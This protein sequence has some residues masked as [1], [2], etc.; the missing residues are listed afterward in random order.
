MR[1]NNLIQS[2]LDVEL[3]YL[4]CKYLVLDVL[5][6]GQALDK[7]VH[8]SRSQL[9]AL[10]NISLVVLAAFNQFA[11]KNNDCLLRRLQLLNDALVGHGKV[12]VQL[13]V[14]VF[15]D[16]LRQV[17][18]VNQAASLVVV[19]HVEQLYANSPI[20]LCLRCILVWERC[21]ENPGPLRDGSK[22]IRLLLFSQALLHDV[23]ETNLLRCGG[24]TVKVGIGG[25]T[26]LN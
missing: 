4:G 16:D 12:P 6:V 7:R 10:E 18:H 9:D 14:L 25:D 3:P 2:F 15:S 21:F 11:N 17:L 5:E 13:V 24:Q 8:I 23:L 22:L 19:Y 1:F 20:F 26:V